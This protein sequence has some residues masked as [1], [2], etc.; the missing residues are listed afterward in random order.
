MPQSV[1]MENRQQGVRNKLTVSMKQMTRC[2]FNRSRGLPEPREEKLREEQCYCCGKYEHMRYQC[3]LKDRCLICGKTGH[4][5][6]QCYLVQD[7]VNN[8]NSK[9]LCI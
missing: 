3:P 5:F 6:R 9:I 2:Y 7:R 4:S 8:V 1:M